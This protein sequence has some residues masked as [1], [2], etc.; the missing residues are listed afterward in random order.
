MTVSDFEIVV[1]GAGHAGCEAALVAARMGARI[2]V[3]TLRADR[4]AQMS[5]NPAVGGV[6]KGHLVRE[7]DALGGA[8][9]RVA[10][11][12]GIQ[13]KR[14]N[15]SRGPAV[16]ST[17]CQSDSAL[18]REA[19]T[20]V[21]AS[22]PGL[23]VIEDEV[24]GLRVEKGRVTG[25]QT[26]RGGTVSCQAVIVTTGTF[27]NGL[28]HIGEENF[29]G[30]RVGDAPANALSESLKGLGLVLGRFKTGTTPRLAA[31]SIDWERCDPQWGDAPRPTFSF[32]RV[33]NP[34]RQIACYITYT[35]SSTHAAVRSGLSRSPLYRGIIEGLGPR[36]CP[37]LEDKVVRFEE[38]D[39]HQVFLEPEGLS[40]DRVYPNGLS[41]SLPRDVQE[42]FLKTI[43][44]LERCR[45]LQHGYAVEYD[46]SPPTQ[47]RPDLMTKACD[48]LYLAGQINGTS[49]Y[50]EAAAQGLLAGIHAVQWINGA[51]A[52]RPGR[53]EA[54]LGVLVDDLV[55]KG[56]DEPYRL[57]TSR[58][59]HRLTLRESNAE[60]RLLGTARRLGLLSADRL[61]RAEQR[62]EKRARLRELARTTRVRRS[63]AKAL[64][65]GE[66]AV[67]LTVGELV[68][69]PELTLS[70]VLD[71]VGLD[72]LSDAA[73]EFVEEELK[74]E[75]YIAREQKEIERLR[76]LETF[77][78][79]TGL[80]FED[81]PGLSRE[82]QEKLAEVR[83]VTLGQASR[84]PGMTPAAL[85]ILRVHARRAA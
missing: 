18:Y 28:C 52:W 14:L 57:F 30:G 70:A 81:A 59:E 75:G 44:G 1:V 58:A 48:G 21:V 42:Q 6:G 62:D 19:M 27:L 77:V 17:R 54:Y 40:S 12:T 26:R 63:E 55:T 80:N 85:A 53:E 5:C 3:V 33:E 11:A 4:V 25:V 56:V 50:E 78:L 32:D 7:I 61:R 43:P 45:V 72:P 47:L 71:A 13:Y 82:V 15:R 84:I 24:T 41:T 10:D 65:L 38:R 66:N 83:P 79:P 31:D 34:H 36:Y 51:E 37:S 73:V 22:S 68:R 2:A 46:Y 60:E 16:R 69:R 39:R 67:G 76:E 74:Y 29:A 23:T 8:M 9:G 20:E 64:G 35:D 49:G